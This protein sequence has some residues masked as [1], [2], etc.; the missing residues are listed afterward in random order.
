MSLALMAAACR[1]ICYIRRRGDYREMGVWTNLQ[2][3]NVTNSRINI[4]G[5]EK[6]DLYVRMGRHISKELVAAVKASGVYE[7]VYSLDPIVLSYKNMRF[8]KIPHFKVLLLKKAYI[9][10][11]NAL[12]DHTAPNKEYIRVLMA[13]FYAENAF[14]IDYFSRHTK[15]LAI[16][17][18][19]E[20][21]GSYCYKKK[22]LSFPMFM[23]AHWKD[24]LRRW[25][26]EGLIAKR[27]AKN[28]DTICL[29]R[30]E[31]CQPD[32]D[33]NKIKL[34]QIR[35][36]TNPVMYDIL[37]AS[38]GGLDATHFIRYNKRR[39]IYFS[40]FSQE[41]VEFDK[42]SVDILDTMVGSS[43]EKQA[44]AKIHTGNT[45]HAENFA[46]S[47]EDRIFI[48]RNVYIFESLYAQ[49]EHPEDKV[50]VSCASTATLNP[51]FMFGYEPYVIFTYR[52]YSRYRQVGVERD[53]WIANALLD[54]YEDKSKVLIPNS[55]HELQTM[56]K[57]IHRQ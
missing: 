31:Y 8:G 5:Q 9:N 26:T 52:L 11:Y 39:Y 14:V 36:D 40:L 32:I 33:Y 43:F 56:I 7:N 25:L 38:A 27:L 41:G 2:I 16:T 10:A 6:A 1:Y 29:Y 46:K 3:I 20:G 30:P 51:K 34:P 54:A 45:H 17:L 57:R 37:C 21:T 50:L 47:Y 13:W 44:I 49:L 19:D 22:E 24:K 12:L 4:Y 35:P 15:H 28:I 48:D 18:V 23:A 42:T 55:M 53:D